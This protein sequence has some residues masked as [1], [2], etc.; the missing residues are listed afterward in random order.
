[1]QPDTVIRALA[2]LAQDHR[3]AAFRLLVEAGPD[4]IAAGVLAEATFGMWGMTVQF[5]PAPI[6][7]QPV[8]IFA[9]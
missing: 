9:E 1:M 8:K 2:A 4:G 5:L 3:L 6:F 7:P